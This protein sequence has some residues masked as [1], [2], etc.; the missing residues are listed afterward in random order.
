MP[1]YV[2]GYS[3]GEALAVVATYCILNDSVGS[4]YTSGGPRVGRVSGRQSIGSSMQ[5]SGA[6][7]I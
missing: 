1:L 7:I 4:N 2:T 3:L 6:T 5:Q